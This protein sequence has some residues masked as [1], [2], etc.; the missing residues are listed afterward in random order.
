[1]EV[2]EDKAIKVDNDNTCII[3]LPGALGENGTERD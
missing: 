3:S 1:M 2:M